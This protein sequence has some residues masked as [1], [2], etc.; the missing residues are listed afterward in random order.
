MRRHEAMP[1][2]PPPVRSGRSGRWSVVD[3]GGSWARRPGPLLILLPLGVTGPAAGA[4]TP[5]RDAGPT[6]TVQ[7]PAAPSGKQLKVTDAPYGATAGK[8]SDD[9][10]AAFRSAIAAA[11]AGDEVLVPKGN[12]VFKKPNVVLKDG[13][14]I[15][16]ESGAVITA[17]F[18]SSSDNAGS[19][20][21]SAPAG[22]DN[23]TIS[24]LRLTSSGGKALNYPL[25]IGS[26]SG[27]NVS[28][29]AIR[30]VQIDKFYRMAIS[31]RNG[32]NVTIEKN[33]I[34]DALATGD[35]GQGYGIMIGY[36]KATNNR[37]ADNV[38]QGPAM[39]HGI[40]LQYGAHH[41]LVED[42]RVTKTKYDAYDLHGEDEY[43]NELR[44]NTA[45]GCGEGGFGVGNTGAGHANAGAGNWIHHN[46]VTGCKWGI[47]IYRK[48]DTQYVED[49]TFSKQLELRHHG[50][51]RGR[52]EPGVRPEHGA[53][54]RFRRDPAGQGAWRAADRQ[55][56]ARQ[57]AA[58]PCRPTRPPPA[59][60]SSATTSGTT[61]RASSSAPAAAAP[62]RT[63]SKAPR[64]SAA[65]HKHFGGSSGKRLTARCRTASGGRVGTA[66]RAS[67][68]SASAPTKPLA[69]S[70]SAA[71]VRRRQR[72]PRSTGHAERD[73]R[74]CGRT[75][76][77][78]RRR[79]RSRAR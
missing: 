8:D 12:Y 2:T 31:V 30:N 19:S 76:A 39:R 9:D 5:A 33:T 1:A 71:A 22:T 47:H 60:G 53:G 57:Q 13:V 74:T 15:T 26:S 52:E 40:L 27:S 67:S 70:S 18:T 16:G 68:A 61:P 46:T 56:G 42:N 21:F 3:S 34:K 62:T 59:S 75:A 54:Q 32:D 48:S 64:A 69:V 43:A 11:K 55:P 44:D 38:V 14:S 20:L 7:L 78:E 17:K 66:C 58:T 77:R 79:C 28:R 65:P 37:V 23:L 36:P 35:G 24:G 50:A 41:N 6:S 63:T 51:R 72:R 49:N 25:W 73:R 10:S 4:A 45:E 29:I